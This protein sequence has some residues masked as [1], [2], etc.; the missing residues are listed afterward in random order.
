MQQ[1]SL[2]PCFVLATKTGRPR[3]WNYYLST[4]EAEDARVEID[5][6]DSQAS[7]YEVT[8]LEAFIERQ[9]AFYMDEIGS[10]EEISA[11]AWDFNLGVLPPL[12]WEYADGVE[13]FMCSEFLDGPFTRQ[14]A[15]RGDRFF[16]RIVDAEDASTWIT[17][18]MIDTM[19]HDISVPVKPAGR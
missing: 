11:E 18:G 12:R 14:Y 1:T 17:A 15:R 5:R 4:E 19:W 9:R 3:M 2:F 6:F 13:R 7:D 8:T 10:L 16:T